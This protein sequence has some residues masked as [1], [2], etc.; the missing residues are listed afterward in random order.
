MQFFA[1]NVKR[2]VQGKPKSGTFD[3]PDYFWS[4][5]EAQ[6]MAAKLF[7]GHWTDWVVWVVGLSVELRADGVLIWRDTKTEVSL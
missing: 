2:R 6:Y 3:L 1:D 5:Q 7:G 4:M